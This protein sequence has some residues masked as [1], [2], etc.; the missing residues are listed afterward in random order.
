ME[1]SKRRRFFGLLGGAT[2]AAAALVAVKTPL[3]SD[4]QPLG[5]TAQK[6]QPAS[7]YQLTEHVR[8]YYETT[9]S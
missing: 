9:L 2:A 5:S 3:G 8:R 6:D 4:E 1:Q 7:G